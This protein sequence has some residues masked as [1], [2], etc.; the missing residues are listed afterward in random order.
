MTTRYRERIATRVAQL[1]ATPGF[2]VVT[3]E[4]A[5]PATADDLARA[6]EA[7]GGRLP[8]GLAE[9]CVELNGFQL[10]W[11]YRAVESNDGPTGEP[12]DSGSV[13]LLPM[14]KIF[15]DWQDTTWFDD[16]PGGGR[17][18]MVKPVDLYVP[19]ACAAFCQ[20]PG[21]CSE[22]ATFFH[23]FGEDLAPLGLGFPEYLELTI[24]TCGYV[25]WRLALSRNDPR[26]PE[27]QPTLNR[28]CSIIPGLTEDQIPVR[29]GA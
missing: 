24:A 16:S 17:F 22:D 12:T 11:E 5:P 21:G 3:C 15:A 19:E 29:P 28:M 10:T 20:P 27:G 6:T 18:V 14:E 8:A 13:N 26:Q 4:F 7:A 2:T 9:F 23:Y 25:N 1:R